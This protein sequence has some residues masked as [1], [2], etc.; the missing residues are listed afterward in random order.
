MAIYRYQ[1]NSKRVIIL[2]MTIFN[3]WFKLSIV[4]CVSRDRIPWNQITLDLVYGFI[5]Y[6][7]IAHFKCFAYDCVKKLRS[8]RIIFIYLTHHYEHMS[9]TYYY[10]IDHSD[11]T[12]QIMSI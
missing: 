10:V 2:A 6:F 5:I 4:C 9:C 1:A 3:I 7:N 11:Y 8:Y 12:I